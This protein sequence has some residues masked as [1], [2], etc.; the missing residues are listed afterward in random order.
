MPYIAINSPAPRTARTSEGTLAL[1]RCEIKL[2]DCS[3]GIVPGLAAG[4]LH[5][6]LVLLLVLYRVLPDRPAEVPE[7]PAHRAPA[8]INMDDDDVQVLIHC[9]G[10]T[11]CL[12]ATAITS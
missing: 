9:L 3:C 7:I 12:S 11:I 1:I 5:F 10:D 4:R 8:H 6:A 2:L